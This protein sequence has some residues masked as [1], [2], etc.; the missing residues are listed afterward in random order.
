MAGAY[1]PAIGGPGEGQASLIFA[2][3]GAVL[4]AIDETH[5][6]TGQGQLV[7]RGHQVAE[8]LGTQGANEV[9]ATL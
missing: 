8:E 5:S 3:P 2:D 9:K 1:L 4:D 6:G 7:E